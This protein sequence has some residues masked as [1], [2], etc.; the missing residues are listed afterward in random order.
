MY[1]GVMLR[2]LC[3]LYLVCSY[4][5]FVNWCGCCELWFECESMFELFLWNLKTIRVKQVLK[6]GNLLIFA[7]A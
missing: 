4:L 6:M 7:F 3:S 1:L 5:M 2:D